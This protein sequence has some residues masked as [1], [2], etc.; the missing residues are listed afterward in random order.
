MTD[1]RLQGRIGT[2]LQAGVGLSAAIVLGGGIWLLSTSGGAPA[3]Y[4]QF[5]AAASNL[6]SAKGVMASLGHPAPDVVIQFGLLLLIATPVAR[7]LFSLAA[8]AAERDFTYVWITLIVL[9]VLA[10]SLAVPHG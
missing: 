3:G 9:G 7:V 10:Y 4:R 2:L 5:H 6:R 8:F 1:Q